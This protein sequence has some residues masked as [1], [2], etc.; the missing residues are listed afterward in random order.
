MALFK[1]EIAA[2]K[3]EAKWFHT[4]ANQL[5]QTQTIAGFN[6]DVDL[7]LLGDSITEAIAWSGDFQKHVPGM[8]TLYYGIGGD[9]TSHVLWR[10]ENGILD[11]I[12]P[13]YAT[14][15]IGINNF[16]PDT[17]AEEVAAGAIAC[18]KAMRAKMPNTILFH[19]GVFSVGS[20]ILHLNGKVDQINEIIKSVSPSYNTQFV[21]M[22]DA[23]L[24]PFNQEI[25]GMLS[26]DG[27]HIT[28]KAYDAW[29]AK[30]KELIEGK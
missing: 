1:S 23:F 21:S 22:R 25:P 8:K 11:G 4:F 9:Q 28:A 24:T 17:S 2:A 10:I 29:G 3:S 13:K 7:L 12:N 18:G 20:G 15:M 27:V 16:W 26:P 5:T 6:G 19:F 30:V 14:L